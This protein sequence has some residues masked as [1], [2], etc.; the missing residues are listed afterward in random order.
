MCRIKTVKDKKGGNL[1]PF[2]FVCTKRNS[3]RLRPWDLTL[4]L[5]HVH[6]CLTYFNALTMTKVKL[7]HY[8]SCSTCRKAIAALKR[9]EVEATL[10][11]IVDSPPSIGEIREMSASVSGGVRK[12]LNTSGELYRT[13]QLK[14]RLASMTD[15]EVE[16]LLSKHGK[17][18]K[19][20]FLISQRIHLVGFN[21]E[22]WESALRS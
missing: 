19:R 7:Y 5:G 2:L 10:V 12:L 14:D 6:R 8:P 18:I 22:L 3:S 17:L 21:E 11:N 15:G 20:P 13:L 16:E 9:Y 4:P 1:S